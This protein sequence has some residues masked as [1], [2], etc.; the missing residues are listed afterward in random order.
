MTSRIY[1][2]E[3]PDGFHLVQANTKA[4]A[5]RYVAEKTH[6]VSVANQMT[7]VGAMKDGIQIEVVGDQAQT[8]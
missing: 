3:G 4:S 8:E 5:L 2:V 1:A 7:L 6:K